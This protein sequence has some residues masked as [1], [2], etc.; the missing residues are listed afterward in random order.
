MLFQN[1][2]LKLKIAEMEKELAIFHSIQKDLVEE[3]LYFSVDRQGV[4]V[5]ANPAFLES[6]GYNLNEL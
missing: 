2:Q 5:D 6:C 3:M 4:F 1:K